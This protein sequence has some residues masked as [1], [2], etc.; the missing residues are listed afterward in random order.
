ME[1][2]VPGFAPQAPIDFLRK[3]KEFM[4]VKFAVLDIALFGSWVK[5]RQKKDS[6]LDL[7]GELKREGKTFDNYMDLKIDTKS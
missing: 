5:S 7:L 1:K 4:A 6:D 2:M 3:N